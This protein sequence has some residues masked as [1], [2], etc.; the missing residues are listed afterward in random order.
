MHAE[1]VCHAHLLFCMMLLT[2]LRCTTDAWRTDQF[3]LKYLNPIIPHFTRGCLQVECSPGQDDPVQEVGTSL[4]IQIHSWHTSIMLVKPYSSQ[5]VLWKFSI[6]C[7]YRHCAL[8]WRWW[9]FSSLL[10]AIICFD[11]HRHYRHQ[12]CAPIRARTTHKLTFQSDSHLCGLGASTR[13][14]THL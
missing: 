10:A 13:P 3:P 2:V 14:Q 7:R 1:R 8:C 5:D 9:S 11:H 4:V 6:H 12:S